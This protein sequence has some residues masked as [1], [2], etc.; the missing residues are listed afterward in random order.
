VRLGDGS[1]VAERHPDRRVRHTLTLRLRRALG[2]HVVLALD[3]RLY[4]DDWGLFGTTTNAV[5]T[6]SLSDAVELELR[7]RLHFQTAASF[8]SERYAQETRY[9]SNDRELATTLDDYVGPGLVITIEDVA[10]FEH[11]RFDLRA[12]LFYYRY[13]GY[14]SLDGRIGTIAALGAEGAF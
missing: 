3:E 1:Y 14:A 13:L 11:L 7:N 12:D 9:V 5:L 10:P 6:F 4:L 8:W 2:E